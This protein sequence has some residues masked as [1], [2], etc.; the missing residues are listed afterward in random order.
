[1]T[2]R[3][4]ASPRVIPADVVTRIKHT[5]N[6]DWLVGTAFV[7]VGALLAIV[8]VG[9]GLIVL[10]LKL[11]RRARERAEQW[12]RV[13]ELGAPAEGEITAVARVPVH[14]DDGH[15]TTAGSIS[16]RIDF[17]FDVDGTTHYG[18]NQLTALTSEGFTVGQRVGVV[19]D[20][21]DVTV[22]A[23]WPPVT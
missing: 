3:P 5:N 23:L 10:G 1:M 4:P 22:A 2:L 13:L 14:T 21:E 6:V 9:I 15:P 20:E 8:I 12:L 18:W 19:Y 17:T 7:A 16:W 11:R